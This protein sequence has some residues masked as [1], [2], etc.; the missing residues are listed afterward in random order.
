MCEDCDGY[1]DIK[2]AA[3]DAFPVADVIE[4]TRFIE[5]DLPGTLVPEQMWQI[6]FGFKG[7]CLDQHSFARIEQAKEAALVLL[8]T[9]HGMAA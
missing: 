8:N 3:D 9:A 7:G 6:Y 4:A 2:P 1:D 5:A